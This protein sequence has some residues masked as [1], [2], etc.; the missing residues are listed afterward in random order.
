MPARSLVRG[1]FLD[2]I[3][4]LVDELP[5]LGDLVFGGGGGGAR[6]VLGAGGGGEPFTGAQQVVEVGGQVGQVGD[7]GAEVVAAGAPEP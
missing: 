4:D 7:V 5:D 1:E 6:P 3:F 2:V